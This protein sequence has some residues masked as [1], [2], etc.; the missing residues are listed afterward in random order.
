M[1][2]VRSTLARALSL[3]ALVSLA[4]VTTAA[5]SVD[6][7]A[8]AEPAA[9]AAPPAEHTAATGAALTI[10]KSVRK[11]GKGIFNGTRYGADAL[12]F[13]SSHWYTNIATSG[14]ATQSSTLAG[15]NA[16]A[17]R[18]IDGNRGGVF[19]DLSVTHTDATTPAPFWQVDFAG[20]HAVSAVSVWN[21]TDCCT[22][23][24]NGAT[25]QVLDSS[26]NVV[27][28]QSLAASA[29]PAV[30]G[31]V[32]YPAVS[33]RY[34]RVVGTSGQYLSLAEV[35]VW[36]QSVQ[37]GDGVC[38]M[39]TK[40]RGVGTVPTQCPGGTQQNGAL[41]YPSC[42]P[43]YYGVGPVCWSYCPAGYTDDGATCRRDASIISANNSACPWYD[44][45]GLTFAKG[46]STCPSG[47]VDD[48][49]TCR[50]DVSIIAKS[51][52]GRTAGQ[53]MTCSANLQYDA[54]LCYT[55][56]DPGYS[57]VGPVCWSSCPADYPVA[58]GA[59]CATSQAECSTAIGNM[60]SAP[61]NAVANISEMVLSFGSSAAV[62]TGVTV[63]EAG[64][65]AAVKASLQ[66]QLQDFAKE[67]GQAA[68]ENLTETVATGAVTGDFDWASIDPTGIAEVVM[69]F[70][71]PICD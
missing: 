49:C 61:L 50:R 57:G 22:E 47:Y 40:T 44:T 45:C 15:T 26:F 53:S 25:V 24:L 52:Y 29:A 63:A 10:P 64:A 14:T 32:F 67:Q 51:S 33:G 70:N 28:T 43:G 42:A 3:S 62:E 27:G 4:A 38:W 16:D 36:E 1:N 6:T 35:E 34:V 48:G 9:Q 21:R 58:C 68:L 13:L 71:Q 59:L 65:K 37:G 60:V 17:S 46:C 30:Q 12:S 23:R 55:P 54:G 2:A 39:K 8:P 56:C 69:T 41:C 7:T 66:A 18:A 11:L 5:C 20:N 19:N 31:V